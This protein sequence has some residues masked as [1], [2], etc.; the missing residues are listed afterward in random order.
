ME[1]FDALVQRAS[2]RKL[3]PVEVTG[4]DLQRILDAGRRAPSGQNFQPFDFLVI[5]DP[6]TLRELSRAQACIGDVTLAVALILTLAAGTLGLSGMKL[7]GEGLYKLLAWM[8]TPSQQSDWRQALVPGADF[9]PTM[10]QEYDAAPLTEAETVSPAQLE[11][12]AE[13]LA[14]PLGTVKSR[15]S[16]ALARLRTELGE[17]R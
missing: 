16:R 10:V 14:L 15:T 9:G 13:V 6:D 12:T 3:K 4:A 17:A 2:V 5:R 7:D 8:P 1:L 11:K